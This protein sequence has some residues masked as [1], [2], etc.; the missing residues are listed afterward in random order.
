[1]TARGSFGCEEVGGESGG[2]V[3]SGSFGRVSTGDGGGGGVTLG[4]A[5]GEGSTLLN[6]GIDI[7][8]GVGEEG[9]S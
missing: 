9:I 7:F 5:G 8:E 1:M 4:I 3:A 6:D 2:G